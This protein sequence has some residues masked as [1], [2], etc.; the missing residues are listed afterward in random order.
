[1]D[2]V[3]IMKKSWGLIPK[4]LSGEKTIESRWYK[5]RHT[6]WDKIKKGDSV[7]FKNSGEPITVKTPVN[8][9]LQFDNLNSKKVKDVLNKYNKKLGIEDVEW[10]CEQVKDKKYCILVFLSDPV[11]VKPFNIN[12]SGF[13]LMS[14][15]ISLEKI[16]SIEKSLL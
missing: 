8:K 14:A 15:W 12:K 13:G 3:A 5:T 4:I 11:K 7:Y 10:F 6:P 2:H 1:M 16:S 9:V